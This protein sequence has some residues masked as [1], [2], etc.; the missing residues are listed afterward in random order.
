MRGLILK[1]SV[2]SLIQ[3]ST[4]LLMGC[5][6]AFSPTPITDPL[7]TQGF[8]EGQKIVAAMNPVGDPFT[9]RA[10]EFRWEKMA[11]RFTCG[12]VA[13]VQGCFTEPN[14][15]RYT[16]GALDVIGH[17]AGHAILFRLGDPRWRKCTGGHQ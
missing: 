17:E 3:L 5:N 2:F 6:N 9:V 7:I 4:Q 10:D 14:R 11:G 12:D 15:V 13:G 1:V 16:A 8:A